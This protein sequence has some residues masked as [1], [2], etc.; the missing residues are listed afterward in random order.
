MKSR[1]NKT[2]ISFFG[3]AFCEHFEAMTYFTDDK[4]LQAGIDI[5]S[6]NYKRLVL[7]YG[8]NK[9]YCVRMNH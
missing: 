9:C 6:F 3:G 4:E 8:P 5:K 2:R 1:N 7:T